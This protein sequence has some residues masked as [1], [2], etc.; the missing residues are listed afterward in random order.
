[1]MGWNG[2]GKNI[3]CTLAFSKSCMDGWAGG[4]WELDMIDT[5]LACY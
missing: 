5:A 3:P 1:M 4:V 2:M